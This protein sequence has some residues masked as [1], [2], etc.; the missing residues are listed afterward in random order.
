MSGIDVMAVLTAVDQRTDL[1]P[2]AR[3]AAGGAC[4][5]DRVAPLAEGQIFLGCRTMKGWIGKREGMR[6]DS[7]KMA[8]RVAGQTAKT[9]GRTVHLC[10]SSLA[11]R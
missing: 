5:R 9:C 10:D 11:T 6:R 1:R 7:R 4:E 2:E 3:I 8:V